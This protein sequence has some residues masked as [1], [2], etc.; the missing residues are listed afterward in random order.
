MRAIGDIDVVKRTGLAVD[1]DKLHSRVRRSTD[2][3]VD[4][5]IS[6]EVGEA[7][8]GNMRCANRV[9]NWQTLALGMQMDATLTQSSSQSRWRRYGDDG[10]ER[11]GVVWCRKSR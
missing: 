9:Q 1:G 6:V 5:G 2:R 10:V 7:L 3:Q 8:R 11:R 4:G